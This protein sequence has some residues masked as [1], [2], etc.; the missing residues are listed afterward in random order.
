MKFTHIDNFL[1]LLATYV[2]SGEFAQLWPIYDG[3]EGDD[4]VFVF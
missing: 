1:I 4:G 2:M 3:I